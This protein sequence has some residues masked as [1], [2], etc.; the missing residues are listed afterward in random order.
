M[1]K[2]I[3]K[4]LENDYFY[5]SKCLENSIPHKKIRLIAYIESRDQ[6]SLFKEEKKKEEKNEDFE[7]VEK[8]EYKWVDNTN[9]FLELRKTN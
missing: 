4:L 3:E 7:N 6:S 9:K 1:R 8:K 5:K 2:C